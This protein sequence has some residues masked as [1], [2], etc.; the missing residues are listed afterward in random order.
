M[1]SVFHP[2]RHIFAFSSWS[3]IEIDGCFNKAT[4]IKTMLLSGLLFIA[5]FSF[6]LMD[7]LGL[8]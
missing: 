5:L 4:D 1:K 8:G 2:A 6:H 3:K 7:L